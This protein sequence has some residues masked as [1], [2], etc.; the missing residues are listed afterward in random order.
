MWHLYV[1][2]SLADGKDYVGITSQ[3]LE[4]RLQRHNSGRVRSTKGR[5][6]FKLIYTE[7]HKSADKAREREKF[8]KSA[9]GRKRLREMM[10]KSEPARGGQVD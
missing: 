7:V 6:P 4:E 3:S 8:F 5:C 2:T 1:L 10:D 9:A